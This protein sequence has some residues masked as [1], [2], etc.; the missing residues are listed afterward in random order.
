MSGFP[1]LTTGLIFVSILL[2][3]TPLVALSYWHKSNV[4]LVQFTPYTRVY[5]Y[6]NLLYAI[7]GSND[8]RLRIEIVDSKGNPIGFTITLSG[9][10]Q[11][12]VVEAGRG[13]GLGSVT[14]SI[15]SYVAEV[16]RV[17]RMLNSPPE[18][19]GL[20][21]LALISTVIEE[22]GELYATGDAITIPII[23]GKAVG[24]DIIVRHV[25]QPVF[26]YKINATESSS[27]PSSG[28]GA[29]VAKPLNP[30]TT[31]VD[32]CDWAADLSY[33]CYEWR[34]KE[35]IYESRMGGDTETI[36]ID[37]MKVKLNYIPLA[38][39]WLDQNAG[40]KTKRLTISTVI[41]LRSTSNNYVSITVGF[42]ILEG[43][44]FKYLSPGTGYITEISPGKDV[45]VL[46]KT[47]C[48]IHSQSSPDTSTCS[49]LDDGYYTSKF[50]GDVIA[51]V[52]FLAYIWVARY[53]YGIN[54]FNA[55]FHVIRDKDVAVWVAPSFNESRK[56]RA[57]WEV[58]DN[59]GDGYGRT[60]KYI[61]KLLKDGKNVTRVYISSGHV[62]LYTLHSHTIYSIS[63]ASPNFGA[64]LPVGAIAIIALQ[65]LGFS[66][67]WWLALIL[68]TL[69]V[70]V[71]SGRYTQDL[72]TSLTYMDIELTQLATVYG[73]FY[74]IKD[75]YYIKEDA[76]VRNTPVILFTPVVS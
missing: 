22:N 21:L 53:E 11:S 28:S 12:G 36:T 27:N 52:G 26:K 65:A 46:Y 48:R 40:N 71:E 25:F 37:S 16:K 49:V 1:R 42:G 55:G 70:G 41:E 4:E 38:V 66:I 10:S 32:Y 18:R 23:P 73:Y 62:S 3:L 44:L 68:P 2:A 6:P 57:W 51:S 63:Q 64:S 43:N 59:P 14:L 75:T 60:E 54:Y 31:I 76:K 34:L 74:M 17:L 29:I 72:Y 5:Y 7:T 56:I 58:D 69:V 45:E 9:P 67:P 13:R 39:T 61:G 24:K 33:F 35:I 8:T 30:P 15:G 20:G 50:S 19:S 47:S